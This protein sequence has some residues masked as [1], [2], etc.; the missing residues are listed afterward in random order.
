MPQDL[1]AESDE[2]GM[3]ISSSLPLDVCAFFPLSRLAVLRGFSLLQMAEAAEAAARQV[4]LPLVPAAALL[5]ALLTSG[6]TPW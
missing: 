5:V 2:A 4:P 6:S 1:L 3:R